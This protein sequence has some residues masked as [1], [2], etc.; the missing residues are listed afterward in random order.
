ML[1]PSVPVVLRC[2]FFFQAEDGIRDHCVT[3]VQTCALPILQAEFGRLQMLAAASMQQKEKEFT[4]TEAERKEYYE[5]N[6]GVFAPARV[7]LIF[8]TVDSA[9]P[10]SD[11]AAKTLAGEVRERIKGG[12]E[13][14]TMVKQD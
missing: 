11:E 2:Y 13:F 6:R 3:G 4:V 10:A 1:L 12:A 8:F 9:N 14:V 7:K 5:K